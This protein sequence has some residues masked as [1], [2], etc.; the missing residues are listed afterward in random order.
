MQACSRTEDLT[1]V[2]SPQRRG[3]LYPSVCGYV[4]PSRFG[5]GD[6]G[7]GPRCPPLNPP[8]LGV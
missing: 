7:L 1:P 6:R 8:E 3:E 5:K 2:P 4:S